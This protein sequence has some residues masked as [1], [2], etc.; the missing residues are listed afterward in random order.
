MYPAVSHT[1]ASRTATLSLA[2]TA[3]AL[4]LLFSCL[5]HRMLAMPESAGGK[6]YHV[7]VF[8]L[9]FMLELT[10]PNVHTGFWLCKSN[11]SCHCGNWCES[12][13]SGERSWPLHG[14]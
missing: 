6:I 14:V 4:S 3:T 8:P 13:Q 2:V 7:I 10:I 11:T 5:H 1:H 9:L 12:N